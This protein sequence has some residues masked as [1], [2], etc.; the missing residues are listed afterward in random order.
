MILC[1]V[2]VQMDH[3]LGKDPQLRDSSCA[4]SIFLK[5]SSRVYLGKKMNYP[6]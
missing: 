3:Y 2:E 1:Y 6:D 5:V 4:A